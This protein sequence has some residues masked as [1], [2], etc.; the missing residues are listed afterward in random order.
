MPV[1]M[2]VPPP[3]PFEVENQQDD[4]SIVESDISGLT[5][6]LKDNVPAPPNLPLPPPLPVAA[7]ARSTTM[8]LKK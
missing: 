8:G 4:D 7:L 2:P 1:G 3:L 6:E 5:E